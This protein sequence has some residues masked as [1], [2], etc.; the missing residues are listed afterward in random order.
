MGY[1]PV[2]ST[3]PFGNT[4]MTKLALYIQRENLNGVMFFDDGFY[5][6]RLR[7]LGPWVSG[8]EFV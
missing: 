4:E 3:D 5:C 2:N 7:L 8:D 6:I 1:G